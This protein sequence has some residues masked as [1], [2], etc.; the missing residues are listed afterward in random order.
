MSDKYWLNIRRRWYV[1]G[2]ALIT[3]HLSLITSSCTQDAYDKGEGRYSQM[4]AEMAD[5]YT[6]ADGRVTTFVTDADERF[7]VSNPFT[8]KLMPKADTVYR[9]VFYYNK[10]EQ[11]AEVI[12]LDR[13][14]VITPRSISDMKTDPVRLESVWLARS[15]RYL[16]LSVWL[17][18]GATDDEEA[19]QKIGCHRDTLMVNADGTSTLHLRLYHDQADVPQYYSA[20][21]YMSIPLT[22][23]EADSVALTINT[24]DG[25]IEK[26]FAIR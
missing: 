23:A 5:G 15:H 9:A 4:V 7:T 10:V 16:N 1:I 21:T 11:G 2:V 22:E 18:L 20:R 6:A 24:Y 8:S 26:R 25:L 12:G 14:G 13:V 3:C 19:V 17:M